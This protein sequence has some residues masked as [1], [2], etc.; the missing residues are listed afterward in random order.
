[1]DKITVKHLKK[2]KWYSWFFSKH[3][4]IFLVKERRTYLE[5]LRELGTGNLWQLLCGLLMNKG[6]KSNFIGEWLTSAERHS[7]LSSTEDREHRAFKKVS[8]WFGDVS[9]GG[10]FL[11]ASFKALWLFQSFVKTSQ[12]GTT[13]RNGLQLFLD[14]PNVN[15]HEL[16]KTAAWVE[17]KGSSEHRIFNS[18]LSLRLLLRAMSTAVP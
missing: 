16:P 11:G 1:M 12:S 17:L 8:W 3:C 5:T 13:Y 9:R 15:L 18:I 10:S 4:E 7:V 14:A 2:F 6:I